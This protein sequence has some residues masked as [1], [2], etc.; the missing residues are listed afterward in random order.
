M[1]ASSNC[2]HYANLKM[3]LRGEFLQFGKYTNVFVYL[4]DTI[5]FLIKVSSSMVGILGVGFYV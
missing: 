4:K 2:A 5:C 3:L 1:R